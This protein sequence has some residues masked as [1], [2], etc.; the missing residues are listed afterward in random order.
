MRKKMEVG[1]KEKNRFLTVLFIFSLVFIL[2]GAS[3][4]FASGGT[5]KGPITL[6]TLVFK[7]WAREPALQLQVPVYEKLTGVKIQ[8]EEVP[9]GQLHEKMI[10]DFASKSGNYDIVT[11]LT[12][13]SP[14]MIRGEYLAPLDSYI[15]KDPP[16]DWPN[17]FPKAL[18]EPQMSNGKLY[19]LPCHDGP[20]MF[21]Y[22]KDLFENPKEKADFKAKYNYDLAPAETWDQFLDQCKFFTRPDKGLT[23]TVLASKQGGQQLPYDFFIML[24]SY[25]GQIFDKAYHPTFNSPAGVDALQF[26]VDLRNKHNVTP[27]AST[28]Y[29]ETENGP[30]YLE[31][32]AATMWH[33]SH[34]AVWAEMPDRSKIIG[35]NGIGL[36]P[37]A[38][39]GIP[40]TTMLGYWYFAVSNASKHKDATYKAINWLTNKA[41]DK[42]DAQNG[43]VGCRF[44]TYHDPEILKQFP[45]YPSIEKT[46]AAGT[47]TLPKVPEYAQ[48]DDAIGVAVSKVLA[49]ETTAKA[50]LDDAAAKVDEMMKK[51]GYYK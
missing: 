9:F 45:F 30:I 43:T 10:L 17:A 40:H 47:N 24:W 25:G 41:N 20:I 16:E 27:K 7:G 39:K 46:L 42:L 4:V 31:G 22:R 8:I 49:G 15:A 37:V 21:Y 5:E 3:S 23:G 50:A 44:S 48:I 12:D 35:Q 2:V 36:V 13:W 28:T 19:G 6:R 38:K 14:E 18:L 1:M 11:P 26:Y 33:W 32:N 51:A 29:D 34:I